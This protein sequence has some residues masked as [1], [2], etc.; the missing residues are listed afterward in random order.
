MVSEA[1]YVSVNSDFPDFWRTRDVTARFGMLFLHWLRS[2]PQSGWS[3]GVADLGEALAE[4][5]CAHGLHHGVY[6]PSGSGLT[7]CVL[8]LAVPMHA[9]G[10]A[11]AQTRCATARTITFVRT[12]QQSAYDAHRQTRQRTATKG[13]GREIA[14]IPAPGEAEGVAHA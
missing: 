12:A 4:H 13:R 5:A 8:A 9:A 10:W 11:M 3:G 2:L 1:V 7:R 14:P 6:V